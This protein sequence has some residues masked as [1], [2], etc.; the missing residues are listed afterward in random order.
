[1]IYLYI[2][3]NFR[4]YTDSYESVSWIYKQ[5]VRNNITKWISA[6]KKF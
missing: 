5:K 3:S 1:M 2:S 6:L 4:P